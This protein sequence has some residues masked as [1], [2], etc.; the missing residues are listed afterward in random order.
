[1]AIYGLKRRGWLGSA[2]TSLGLGVTTRALTNLE[3]RRLIGIDNNLN[4]FKIEKTINIDAPIDR[5]FDYWSHPENFPD[6]MSHIREVRRI[7]DGLY[8]WSV[9]GPA[10][11]MA[12]WYAG[13][14]ELEFN[15]LLAWKSLPGSIIGQSGVTRFSANPDGSTRVAVQMR[16][17]PPAGALGHS[18]AKLFG[19]DPKHEMDDDLMLMKSFIETGAHPH[20]AARHVPTIEAGAVV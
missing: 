8:Q 9:G 12:R 4:G 20:D 2:I 10:G 6:F 1:M 18:I 11:L 15:K 16:Y 13:I 17:I 7:G 19:V 14:T 5:V 3:A